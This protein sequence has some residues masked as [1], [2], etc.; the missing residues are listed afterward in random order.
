MDYYT[1]IIL[2]RIIKHLHVTSKPLSISISFPNVQK[3]TSL[4]N[5]GPLKKIGFLHNRFVD[6][7][8]WFIATSRNA[9]AVIAGC[10]AAYFLEQNGSKPFTL[11]GLCFVFLFFFCFIKLFK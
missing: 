2:T 11:T 7:N 4:K 8:L 9:I 1:L 10:L 3:L 6:G 5:L